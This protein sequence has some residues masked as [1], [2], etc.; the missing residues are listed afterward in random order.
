MHGA[1]HAAY[2]TIL[3]A[4]PCTLYP[5]PIPPPLLSTDLDHVSAS[6]LQSLIIVRGGI[7]DSDSDSDTGCGCFYLSFDFGGN[8]YRLL[9]FPPLPLLRLLLL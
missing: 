8:L 6:A 7:S 1:L 4:I 2:S 5:L 9:P 3:P